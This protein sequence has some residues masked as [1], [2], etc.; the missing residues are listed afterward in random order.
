MR[1][2]RRNHSPAFKA[3]VALAAVKGDRTVADLA[4]R[5]EIHPNQVQTWKKQL[6]DSAAAVFDREGGGAASSDVESQLK[7]LHA[8]IG[9]LAMEKDFL[10]KA[11]G[12]GQ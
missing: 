3:K 11:L 6:L 9:E 5:F 4:S 10:S 8:K 1:R 12:R 2:Q 7:N